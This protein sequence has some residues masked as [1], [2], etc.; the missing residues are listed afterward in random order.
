MD[1]VQSLTHIH[2][3]ALKIIRTQ[4]PDTPSI[5]LYARSAK[6]LATGTGHTQLYEDI[7]MWAHGRP[8]ENYLMTD[9]SW[10]IG[11]MRNP[12]WLSLP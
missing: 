9:V 2:D 11:S 4:D 3:L 12:R 1:C 10:G 6:L 7:N 8:T 5:S